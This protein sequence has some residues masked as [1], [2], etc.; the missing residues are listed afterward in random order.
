MLFGRHIIF[1]LVE[2]FS[3]GMLASK[4]VNISIGR[5]G[6]KKNTVVILAVVTL[7]VTGCKNSEEALGSVA[8]QAGRPGQLML[9][10]GGD[11]HVGIKLVEVPAGAGHK[12]TVTSTINSNSSY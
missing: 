5:L 11:S 4:L 6:V 9:A 10:P 12:G 1:Y 8:P 7:A 3:S 2:K